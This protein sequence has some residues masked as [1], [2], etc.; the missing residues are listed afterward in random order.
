MVKML[1]YKCSQDSAGMG[2]GSNHNER[3]IISKTNSVTLTNF[4]QH[5]LLSSKDTIG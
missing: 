2:F 3:H 5:I 1:C 4:M